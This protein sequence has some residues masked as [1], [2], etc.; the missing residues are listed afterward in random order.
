MKNNCYVAIQNKSFIIIES[1]KK[2]YVEIP[3]IPV[4]FHCL[5]LKLIVLIENVL[6]LGTIKSKRRG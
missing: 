1:L 2:E 3:I 4:S 6:E 5:T